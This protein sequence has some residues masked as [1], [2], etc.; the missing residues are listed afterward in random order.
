MVKFN[1][2]N[3]NMK[4]H[5]LLL[6]ILFSYLSISQIPGNGFAC[7]SSLCLSQSVGQTFNNGGVPAT[8]P[9]NSN[10][11]A[12]DNNMFFVFCA[13]QSDVF[14]GLESS[15]C[16]GMGFGGMEMTVFQT[17]D[18]QNFTEIDCISAMGLTDTLIL[19]PSL[20]PGETY[21]LMIDGF[22]M[23][24]CDFRLDALGITDW[25]VPPPVPVLDPVFP[26]EICTGESINVEV[27][28]ID[29]CGRYRF[30]NSTNRLI[31]IQSPGFSPTATITGLEAGFAE[32]CIEYSNL[33]ALDIE[34]FQ[35][36]V[37]ESPTIDP[38]DQF[39]VC[40]RFVDICDYENFFPEP[41]TP[42][43]LANG[44]DYSFHETFGDAN[45]G[46]NP[47][48]CPYDLEGRGLF[49]LYM[50]VEAQN[51]C[52]FVRAF[53]LEFR[54]PRF[55][56]IN[57]PPVCGPTQ[58]DLNQ[59][60]NLVDQFGTV[61]SSVNYYFDEGDAIAQAGA[62]IPPIIDEEG[63][64]W[65]RVN[66]D[67]DP[68][69]STI[70]EFDI[71]IVQTPE[72]D[73]E[74]P[75]IICATDSFRFDLSSLDVIPL[76]GFYALDDLDIRYYE[77]PPDITQLDFR[78]V[79]P[80]V[81][82]PGSYYVVAVVPLNSPL[83]RYC[84]SEPVLIDLNVSPPPRVELTAVPP[85]C[86]GAETELIFE[87]SNG[88]NGDFNL[89]FELSDGQVFDQI[90]TTGTFSEFVTID[91]FTDTIVVKITSFE[92]LDGVECPPEF[93][94]SIL[95]APPE[96]L[97]LEFIGDSTYCE[98]DSAQI[99]FKYNG[100]IGVSVE[101]TD[102]LQFYQ[103]NNVTNG[104]NIRVAPNT[105]TTYTITDVNHPDDCDVQILG[106]FTVT[107]FGIP[108]FEIV[109]I[110]C[111]AN[112]DYRLTIEF[113]GGVS[114]TY[115]IDSLPVGPSDI[116]V[117]GPI[118]NDSM[119][120]FELNDSSNCGPI[121][122]EGVY[123]C[124]C[125][126][127]AGSMSGN[128]LELCLDDLAIGTHNGDHITAQGDDFYFILHTLS[129]AQIGNILD[130]NRLPEFSFDPSDMVPGTIYY[131]S[132]ISGNSDGMGG[133][134]LLDSCTLISAGQPV[135]F[136]ENPTLEFLNDTSICRGEDVSI[137]FTMSGQLPIRIRVDT[138]GVLFDTLIL[139]SFSG[140]ID[141]F[142]IN[143]PLTITI[144][145]I[146]DELGCVNTNSDQILVDVANGPQVSYTQDC[147]QTNT[148]FTITFTIS[149]GTGNYFVDGAP[150]NGN[151]YTVGPYPSGTGA[152]SFTILDDSG[153]ATIVNTPGRNCDCSTQ[154]GELENVNLSACAGESIDFNVLNASILDAD[155]IEL[156]Y[157][158][159]N[160]SDPF[161]TGIVFLNN[162]VIDFDPSLFTPGQTYYV[163][164]AVGNDDGNGNIDL[165]GDPCAS[166][167]NFIE[168]IWFPDP[169]IQITGERD[170]CLSDQLVLDLNLT[171]FADFELTYS[172]NGGS[173]LFLTIPDNTGNLTFDPS[174]PNYG[175]GFYTL[176]IEEL[177]D[178]NGCQSFPGTTV[179]FEVLDT[180]VISNVSVD[181]NQ[182][183]GNYTVS[184]DILGGSGNYFV[185]GQPSSASF[186]SAATPSS[187]GSYSFTVSD[188]SG[189]DT[190]IVFGTVNCNCP[191]P[192]IMSS[193]TISLCGIEDATYTFVPN[194]GIRLFS[195][196]TIE[197]FLHDS[198]TQVLGTVFGRSAT[199]N[200]VFDPSSMIYGQVYYISRV[201][202]DFNGTNGVDLN[203]PCTDVI[204]LGQ[205]VIW[206]EEPNALIDGDPVR[207]IGCDDASI[208][209]DGS[210]SLPSGIA[211]NWSLLQGATTSSSIGNAQIEALTPGLYILEVLNG[212]NICIDRDSV[213]LIAN[214]ELPTINLIKTGDLNC[215]FDS[216]S[217]I[218]TGSDSGPNFINTWTLPDGSISP[219]TD[220]I[221]SA[222]QPGTYSLTIEN[223]TNGCSIS[224]EIEVL[225]DQNLPIVDAG[226]G[227]EFDCDTDTIDLMAS[228][229]G[230]SGIF[231]LQ[232]YLNGMP[233]P[234]FNNL[235]Q[236]VRLPGNY[237][238]EARDRVNGC[239]SRDSVLVSSDTAAIY[240][241]L[242]QALDPSCPGDQ[243]GEIRVQDVQGGSGPYE[244]SL[245]GLPF[246]SNP[247]F[248]FLTEGPH[249]LTVRDRNG[250]EWTLTIILNSPQDLQ[251]NM[252]NDTII[253]QGESIIL[254]PRISGSNPEG[255]SGIDTIYISFVDSLSCTN[256]YNPY[257]EITPL[258]PANYQVTV[259]TE[260]GCIFQ[261]SR[262]ISVRTERPPFYIP[263][264]FSPNGDGINDWVSFSIADP[265][266]IRR[267]SE[268]S[269]YSRWGNQVFYQKEVLPA[270]RV[271]L[272]NGYHNGQ[273]MNPQVFVWQFKIEFEDGIEEYYQGDI[274]LFR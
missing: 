75:P 10:C 172:V 213:E 49:T 122:I 102:G 201:A 12:S 135:V 244:F 129:G 32:F 256:C 110:E 23:D 250:C 146:Q 31:N 94:D 187:N 46:Q 2:I 113:I 158:F 239:I 168:I 95:I 115:T 132:P 120:V 224:Q 180:I 247:D 14:L 178:N 226:S 249:Q 9:L 273:V 241:A 86:L 82:E 179:E 182:A 238:L 141:L 163:G 251:V 62:I 234:G 11:G 52:V 59:Q 91:P 222:T 36:T 125:D 212:I 53:T 8:P 127:Q 252:G 66:S 26:T 17:D 38:I 7:Q 15:N 106:N 83:Q 208:L 48:A 183:V 204:A 96:Q 63:T 254:N 56:E 44:W 219:E 186:N 131:I 267:I 272:W 259:I 181:C 67:T 90:V 149:G 103:L 147:D 22:M 142:E 169:T 65:I 64:Y 148:S 165:L 84:A 198:P 217:L 151:T 124:A 55:G 79:P 154:A 157:V 134:D 74:E 143:E 156:F 1:S 136:Y 262:F 192:G 40:D 159:S 58:I 19:R 73:I 246:S 257:V 34:C 245:D 223:A 51:R 4:Y 98:G 266:F 43:P 3:Q 150:V 236:S 248:L 47:I 71:T 176:R 214:D 109:D 203:D 171:G 35:L 202:G 215:T 243:D 271:Q 130:Q 68:E 88:G 184:F 175:I 80:I 144:P 261:D 218:A 265:R 78:L 85:P 152:Q 45:S 72:I 255:S 155:D 220:L 189:C 77:D 167:G 233:I 160:L 231:D 162:P 173:D 216:I 145:W 61:Y 97:T 111:L 57:L 229:I 24:E 30:I 92:S 116:F 228:V 197:Y 264:A 190:D 99:E 205:P 193:D 225:E 101:Y 274:T 5:L 260:S 107:P 174:E 140:I 263:N 269:I 69:C 70:Q 89:E 210:R 50:R 118:S 121:L 25:T 235:N 42:D 13:A 221:L 211:F 258:V 194:S 112:L 242:Y 21:V 33:C 105:A 87:V 164:I 207:F 138:N 206:F 227:G 199:G 230:G 39:V 104:T 253:D 270:E 191:N 188:D 196:D 81:T 20:T 195:G 126:N 27:T 161:N 29:D 114:G 54:K 268:F 93:G 133:I 123:N 6:F 166:L 153:C 139:N 76:S 16:L 18:C 119:Y 60:I 185:D 200:F 232:W 41:I 237:I 117:S 100:N 177:M 128:L 28:N 37:I 240:N 209:L 137:P 108:D 170:I